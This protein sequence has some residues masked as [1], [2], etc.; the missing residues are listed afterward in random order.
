M[1]AQQ[2]EHT[3]R[4]LNYDSEQHLRL[5]MNYLAMKCEIILRGVLCMCKLP[6]NSLHITVK[7]AS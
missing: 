7:V 6:H 5:V 2:V 3:N 1:P 4:Y